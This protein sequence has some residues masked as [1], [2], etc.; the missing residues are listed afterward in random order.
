V[1]PELYKLYDQMDDL[2][3]RILGY[4]GPIHPYDP[5]GPKKVD[6]PTRSPIA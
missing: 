1:K 5:D 2:L 3:L 6:F 4:R